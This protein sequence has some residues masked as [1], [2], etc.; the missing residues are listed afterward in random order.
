MGEEGSRPFV[1]QNVIVLAKNFAL[2]QAQYDLLNRGLTFVP[3]IDIGKYQ[4]GQFQLDIQTYHRR[5]KL[6]T[7]FRDSVRQGR[8]PFTGASDWSPSFRVLPPEIAILIEKDWKDFKTH[9]KPCREKFNLSQE[10]VKALRELMYNKHIVI[11]PADKGS[12]VVIL[13][14]EQYIFEVERQ[15]NN[16]VYYKKL[17]EPIYMETIPIINS[18]WDKLKQNKFINAKQKQYLKGRV[19]PRERRFYVLPKIHKDPG[20]WT[21]PFELPPGRKIIYH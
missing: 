4:K 1:A 10:E 5:I 7:Y 20:K 16:T 2:S 6:A 18:I 17:R 8:Q 21:V 13:S 9:Y 3:S 12:A 15:L 19:Q 11:K 14:R